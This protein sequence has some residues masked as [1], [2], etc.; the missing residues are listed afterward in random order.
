[1]QPER[2]INNILLPGLMELRERNG[3]GEF[4]FKTI[5]LLFNDFLIMK[6]EDSKDKFYISLSIT[7][8]EENKDKLYYYNLLDL[9]EFLGS[10]RS[11]T[12]EERRSKIDLLI[13]KYFDVESSA[14][15]KHKP[16]SELKRF[17][18]DEFDLVFSR[19]RDEFLYAMEIL[20]KYSNQT[21]DDL[22]ISSL[23]DEL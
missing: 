18:D 2:F 9:S 5:E 21:S 10:L 14:I 13:R 11:C 8:N 16:L 22:T 6:R 19:E 20:N 15:R 7:I 3:N 4:T 12:S 23:I 17:T 1:M